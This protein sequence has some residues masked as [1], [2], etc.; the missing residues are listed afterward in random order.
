MTKPQPKSYKWPIKYANL[1][2]MTPSFWI[3]GR[4]SWQRALVLY[5][6]IFISATKITSVSNSKKKAR[7]FY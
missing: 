4:V 2:K 5:Q 3:T 7:K 6:L 1:V